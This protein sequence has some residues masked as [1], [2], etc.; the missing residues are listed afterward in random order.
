[1]ALQK[2]NAA[3]IKKKAYRQDSIWAFLMILVPLLGFLIFSI[4]PIIWTFRWAFYSYNGIPSETRFIGLQNFVRM[5]TS[6]FSYWRVWGNTLLFSVMKIPVELPLA[7]ILASFLSKKNVK[8]GSLMRSVYYLPNVIS[9][10]VIGLIITCMFTYDG[11]IN[12][13]L[14]KMGL[15][16]EKIDWFSDRMLAM[17]MLVIGSIWSSFG[18]NVMYFQAAL[19]N[20]P[21]DLYESAELDGANAWVKFWK[22][23]F[24]MIMPVFSTI[25]LLSIIG[26]LST[27][28]YILA[29]TNGG[30]S[31]GTQT[32]MSYLTRNFM[33]G[34]VES[35][36]NPPL[37]YGCAMCMV[38]TVLYGV[39][40][41]WYKWFDKKMNN[42]Y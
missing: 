19:C 28:E 1:M 13:T 29:V 7:I 32:V 25:L 6:D 42:L 17:T 31:G 20:V 27:N 34:F 33:P 18:I 22:I 24:P 41:I 15:I 2:S 36:A 37:G 10:V 39:I 35:A 9:A 12:T 11:L 26:T 8:G 5:F 21:E 23:T 40:A 4:Y 38:T 30:P 14:L 16:S 3:A